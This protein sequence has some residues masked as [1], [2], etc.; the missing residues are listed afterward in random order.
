[1]LKVLRFAGMAAFGIPL[2]RCV[3]PGEG[4]LTSSAGRQ[5]D[6]PQDTDH[7]HLRVGQA[8]AVSPKSP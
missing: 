5:I 2:C 3:K 1:M 4:Q 7:R 8:L 6:Q